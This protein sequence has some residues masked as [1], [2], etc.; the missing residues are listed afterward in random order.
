[1][2]FKWF[3]KYKLL[4]ESNLRKL[5]IKLKKSS[6]VV[7]YKN[8]SKKGF[9]DYSVEIPKEIELNDEFLYFFGLWCGDRSGGGRLG[10]L[11][12]NVMR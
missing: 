9:C 11:V 10:D 4:S 2:I 7:S 12:K 6:F 8:Y 1:M 5:N 3:E